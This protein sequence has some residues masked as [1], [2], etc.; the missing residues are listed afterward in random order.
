MQE[1]EARSLGNAV[2][3][4]AKHLKVLIE[5]HC[6]QKMNGW[7][8]AASSEVSGMGLAK[9][10]DGSFVVY[11]VFL[12]KQ[13]CSS[14][15]TELDDRANARLQQ[16]LYRM[17]KDLTHYRFWWHT[18]YNFNVF[19]SGTDDNNAEE[20]A[21]ANGE[22]ELSL[23]INQKGEWRCRVDFMKQIHPM[24]NYE[25]HYLVDQMEVLLIPNSTYRRRK[26]NFRSDIRRWVR[27]MEEL[28]ESQKP[29]MSVSTYSPQSFPGFDY[30]KRDWEGEWD[31]KW[32]GGSEDH[33]GDYE[34]LWS[35]NEHEVEEKK[36]K[37]KLVTF[38]K[39]VLHKGKLVTWEKY[40]KLK[41]DG[42]LDEEQPICECENDLCF[43]YK[44][45]V[46]CMQC[47]GRFQAA[48]GHCAGCA[49]LKEEAT[50]CPD[51]C[52]CPHNVK[53]EDCI[54][55]HDCNVCFEREYAEAFPGE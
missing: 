33:H 18:H 37:D 10:V 12:P 11:D 30:S 19:W 3:L 24:L 54:C 4:D 39:Y 6:W 50:V 16:R 14:G 9:I 20:L 25:A 44:M 45:C 5:R 2:E 48:T 21:R 35:K 34:N 51:K 7:C 32:M 40:H 41:N 29:K 26:R 23:V 55:P 46:P 43:E 28:P 17:G 31:K 36:N 13:Y 53:W 15:Y 42:K 27:P 8:K 47:G 49:K 38:G 1:S 52:K 22:W